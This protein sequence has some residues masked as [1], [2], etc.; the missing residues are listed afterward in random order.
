M[1]PEQGGETNTAVTR[2]K[3]GN[4]LGAYEIGPKL[5]EDG[6]GQVFRARD[7]RLGRDVAIKISAERFNERF[8]REARAIA[9]LNH[10]NICILYDVGPDYI[11]MESVEGKTLAER[12]ARPHPFG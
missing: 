11:V 9:A 2:L 8:Q 10:P 5:G 6:M 3:P 4:R 7:T 1:S 12:I